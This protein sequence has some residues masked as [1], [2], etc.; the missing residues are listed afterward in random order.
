MR[1]SGTP[2]ILLASGA[3]A[4]VALLLGTVRTGADGGSPDAAGLLLRTPA[5][6]MDLGIDRLRQALVPVFL[7]SRADGAVNWDARRSRIVV[8]L[9]MD[10]VDGEANW[11]PP[12]RAVAAIRR[13]LGVDA[14]RRRVARGEEHRLEELFALTAAPAPPAEELAALIRIE[15]AVRI[16]N[17]S[18]TIY[19]ADLLGGDVQ[20][21]PIPD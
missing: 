19:T 8:R 2:R 15:C 12:R 18:P 9:A 13:R 17:L 6:Q 4:A 5:T 7:E 11:D 16:P 3:L 20:L 21:D 10:R 1:L 14:D